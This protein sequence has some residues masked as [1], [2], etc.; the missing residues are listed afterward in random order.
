M[1]KLTKLRAALEGKSRRPLTAFTVADATIFAAILFQNVLYHH[2]TDNFNLKN[3]INHN[4]E[5][6]ILVM[7]F[8]EK[9]ILNVVINV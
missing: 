9:K 1:W 4:F 8:V 7:K 2:Q 5:Y 3:R 6:I